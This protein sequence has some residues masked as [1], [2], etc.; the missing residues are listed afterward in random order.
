[1]DQSNSYR[2]KSRQS[3]NQNRLNF[4]TRLLLRVSILL[5]Y[6]F[7]FSPAI[8]VY[9]QPD[10]NNSSTSRVSNSETQPSGQET[11]RLLPQNSPSSEIAKLWRLRKQLADSGVDNK[12]IESLLKQFTSQ[13]NEKISPEQLLKWADQKKLLQDP[14]HLD[15]MKTFLDQYFKTNGSKNPI[16]STQSEQILK[17]LGLL[18]NLRDKNV[19]KMLKKWELQ[20][21]L[22]DNGLNNKEIESLLQR[23]SSQENSNIPL[24]ELRN[25][26]RSNQLR[27]NSQ[28]LYKI[29][30]I[31]RDYLNSQQAKDS[32]NNSSRQDFS[33]AQVMENLKLLSDLSKNKTEEQL[34]IW[35][36]EKKLKDSG[37]DNQKIKSLLKRFN[38]SENKSVNPR[39]LLR[40][41][42]EN[43]IT[44][45]PRQLTELKDQLDKFLKDQSSNT[46]K[47]IDPSPEQL[48]KYLELLSQYTKNNPNEL[49]NNMSKSFGKENNPPFLSK[50]LKNSPN[51][52]PLDFNKK[53]NLQPP[54]APEIDRSN[55]PPPQLE[56]NNQAQYDKLTKDLQKS[57]GD[58]DSLK[59][60]AKDFAKL[61]EQDYS[62]MTG[63]EGALKD[64]EPLLDNSLIKNNDLSFLLNK[65]NLQKLQIWKGSNLSL[66]GGLG[67]S[68]SNF[69]SGISSAAKIA[70]LVI[71]TILLAGAIIGLIVA[72]RYLQKY[73]Q[74]QWSKQKLAE[75]IELMDPTQIKSARDLI[76]A[77]N[78]LALAQYGRD[79]APWNHEMVKRELSKTFLSLAP[80][81]EEITQLYESARYAPTS[82]VPDSEQIGKGKE[83]YSQIEKGI[84]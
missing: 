44:Q 24:N 23:F 47:E 20:K 71:I 50:Y 4:T 72:Y 2:P 68:S 64:L 8:L 32:S 1:M 17:G 35:N 75:I 37:L 39:E 5:T 27:Q 46:G 58:L 33:Y 48:E 80:Q 31:L 74:E 29:K 79:A 34:K 26:A 11:Y 15:K 6:L 65:E 84:Q 36:L 60:I 70:Q 3:S 41:A 81:I 25:W 9:S 67:G 10:G 52:D 7:F 66:G 13:K 40:W 51:S 21:K 69:A 14:Q 18:S 62:K 61:S 22:T 77:F 76:I 83:F 78:R 12:V 82:E 59:E 63:L 73:N 43:N 45:D 53:S 55:Q 54:P 49:L 19:S 38:T 30:S 42:K 56:K 28:E 57:L 16:D